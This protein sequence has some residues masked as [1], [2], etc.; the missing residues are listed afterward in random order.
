MI[1]EKKSQVSAKLKWVEGKYSPYKEI[2]WYKI[3]DLSFK[4][5]RNSKLRWLQFQT[6]QW[7]FQTNYY[8]HKLKLIESSNCSFCEITQRKLITSFFNVM[9]RKKIWRAVEDL[10]LRHNGHLNTELLIVIC[11]YH[12][13][14]HSPLSLLSIYINTP[15]FMYTLLVS[16]LL[17]YN[18]GK[19]NRLV[20][21]FIYMTCLYVEYV[22]PGIYLFL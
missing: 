1:N 22:Y 12:F 7:I 15:S 17:T 9:K 4:N 10:F 21:A 6:L 20:H 14:F 11:P 5:T 8:L 18:I 19:K 13:P 2:D 3:F 16:I